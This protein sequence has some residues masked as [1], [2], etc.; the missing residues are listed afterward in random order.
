ME[1]TGRGTRATARGYLLVAIAFF[2]ASPASAQF[3]ATA[4]IE[5][6]IPATNTLDATAAGTEVV[7]RNRIVPQITS[8]LIQEAPGTRVVQTGALGT[9]FCLRIRGAAC[10]QVTV[11]LEDVPISSS[12]AGAFDLSLVPLQA[13]A[14]LE[15]YRGG[16]PAWLSDG[17]VGGVLRLLP[18]AYERN[19]VGARATYGSFG[20]WGVNGFGAAAAGKAELFAT[21]GAAG[22][23]NDY[24][25]LDD[26]GTR[27]DPSDD[28]ERTR[29]NADFLEGF[30]FGNLQVETSQHSKLR[31]VF[32][33]LGRERGEP[34]SGSSPALQARVNETRL[35][36][37]AAWLHEKRGDHP[38]RV[39]VAANYD[40]A[41]NRF[42][43]ELGE[44]GNGGPTIT[45]DRAHTAYGRV[46]SSVLVVRW[47]ELTTIA[48]ARYQVFD[49]EDELG[50]D[51]SRASDRVTAAG[52]VETR[53][54][55]KAGSVALELRPS[56]RLSWTRAT[57]REAQRGSAIPPP[58]PSSDLL[59][60]YRVGAAIGPVEWLAF[61]GSVARGYRLPSLLQLFGNGFT[62]IAS[63]DL[64]PEHALSVDGA[65][66]ARGQTG[67][68]NGYVS[69][70]AF[71][72]WIDDMIRFRRTSQSQI[73]YE[74]IASGQTRGVEIEM[75][76]G[77]TPHFVLLGDATWTQAIDEAT[78]NQL[79]GQP[80]WVAFAQP[81]AHSGELSKVVT[82]IMGF[83]R[84]LY[85][86]TSFAD[87]ANLVPLEARTE[88]AAGVGAELFEGLLGLSFRVDDLLDVRGQDL[89]GFPL[90]GR[91]YTG[92]LSIRHTW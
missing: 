31:L 6:P 32:L 59:P 30:G 57:I 33:G 77:L 40:F 12:D 44:L 21:A 34:G 4:E 56:V 41:R 48:S 43:D 60:T 62:V 47:L 11:M 14:G 13:L 74:N 61:R 64:V 63:P 17:S 90:P 85:I 22:A 35:I 8:Q 83:F 91:R 28:V 5:R 65:V 37:S 72:S 82:D 67:V 49:P 70:G 1:G 66:T 53:F 10:D 78:G 54:F 7:V 16:A 27:F 71:A 88:L 29:R 45:D 79:P 46:A 58:P 2:S 87:P 68:L 15:V 36:G 42:D 52:N 86:G 50:A 39:Q 3:G 84:V 80:E 19:E 25:F 9:P 73:K 55:G 23:A 76:G 92:R 26:G 81:E 69:V 18:R 20:T 24:P 51:E 38:Y 89:L 75:R